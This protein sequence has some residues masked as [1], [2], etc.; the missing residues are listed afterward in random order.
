M[1][2]NKGFTLIELLVVIA[3][4][5]LLMSIHDAG[6]GSRKEASAGDG[7]PGEP[8]AMGSDVFA[9]LPGQRRVFLLGRG[10]GA[11]GNVNA[12]INGVT[13]SWATGSGGFWRVV[14]MPY[15]KDI[16]MWLC[17]QAVDASAEWTAIPQ[18][19]WA[20]TAWQTDGT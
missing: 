2:K 11:H 8:Q 9:L 14:M 17:P 4:I 3:I 5:A 7:L 19:T 16:S 15:S 12:T 20:Y 13:R 1:R 18:G 10:Q 6:P